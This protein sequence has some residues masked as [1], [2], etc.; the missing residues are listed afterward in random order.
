MMLSMRYMCKIL[1]S[2]K[3]TIVQVLLTHTWTIYYNIFFTRLRIFEGSV[4]T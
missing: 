1:R 3:K 2:H 4:T